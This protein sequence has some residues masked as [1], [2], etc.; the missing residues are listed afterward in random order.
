MKVRIQVQ[1]AQAKGGWLARA[2]KLKLC[3]ASES[4]TEALMAL[5]QTVAAYCAGLMR[6]E[7]LRSAL[8]R[9]GVEVTGD[10][11]GDCEVVLLP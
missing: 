9:N 1:L 7:T 4:E 6:D 8:Q 5:K 2:P 3:R 10:P 11:D